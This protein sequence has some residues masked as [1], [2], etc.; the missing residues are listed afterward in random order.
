MS[1]AGLLT[2][3]QKKVLDFIQK[4]QKKNGFAPSQQEIAKH[5]G[6]NSLGTVQNYLT[7]LEK[8]GWI[9]KSWN[10][11][12]GTQ[13]LSATTQEHGASDALRQ[14]SF[15]QHVSPPPSSEILSLALIGRVAAGRPIEAVEVQKSVDVPPSLVS[16]RDPHF[17]LEVQGDSMIDAGILDGDYVVIRQKKTAQNGET[18]VALVNNE[19]T[20]KRYYQRQG[21]IEL[22]SANEKYKPII[23]DPK[24][25]ESFSFKI[26]GILAGVIR[27]Y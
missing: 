11:R 2:P 15:S 10:A 24:D 22:H 4:Y 6:F 19:A 23:V 20:I 1:D 7:R 12:R 27:R 25:D 9:Q 26:E 16:Q 8:H 14:K 18:V 21:R 3:K 13:I 17:V 5:F